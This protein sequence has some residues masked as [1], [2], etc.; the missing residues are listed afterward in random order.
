MEIKDNSENNNNLEDKVNQPLNAITS[1]VSQHETEPKK[2]KCHFPT[3]YTILVFIELLFFIL[4]YV[5]PK[6]LFEKIEY[7]SERNI[8]TIK[9]QNGTIREKEA[10]QKTLD[11]LNITI[12]LDNFVN[13]YISDPISIPNTYKEITGE[14]T[15]FFNLFLYPVLGLLKAAEIS[16]F[17]FVLGGNLNIL[18]DMNALAAGMKALGRVTKGKEFVLLIVVFLIMSISGS[19]LGTLEEFLPFY[20]ILMPIYLKS[21][22][23]GMLSFS[24]LY[25]SSMFGNMF[26]T[27]NPFSIMI[28]S[29]SSGVNMIDGIVYRLICYAVGNIFCIL[30][31]F[32]YYRKI[33]SDKTKSIVYDIR[34]DIEK[35]F[36]KDEKEN[37]KKTKDDDEKGMNDISEDNSL[38]NNEDNKE[39][40]EKD[41]FTFRQKISIIIFVLGFAVMIVG[42]VVFK[43]GITHMTSIFIVFGIILMIISGKGEQEALDVFM[44]GA[45]DFIGVSIIIGLARSINI[46]LEEGKISDTLLNYLSKAIDGLPKIVFGIIILLIFIFLGLFISSSSGLAFLSMPVFAPLADQANCS[47]IVI[48]NAY[49]FGQYFSAIITPT[50]YILIVLQMVGIPYNYW[51]KFIW[52]LLIILFILLVILIIINMYIKI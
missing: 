24:S 33:K 2:K 12:P 36:L 10:S 21:G 40:K 4:T 48:I 14:T 19:T 16:F 51:I 47:R 1:T 32:F 15:N 43:W 39:S 31:I 52:P 3:A 34:K 26:S 41:E 38:L 44:R 45:G 35:L 25:L 37:K 18:V 20:Q 17:L 9:S 8:F 30:Y 23:D 50:S 11:E 27:L 5:I 6:G 22:F 28:A 49:M 46:T 29:Y 13:G 7:S 42:A